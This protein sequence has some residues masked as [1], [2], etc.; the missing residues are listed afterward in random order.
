MVRHIFSLALASV[1][2]A[3]CAQT[4]APVAFAPISFV[5][6]A[7]FKI[8]APRIEIVEVFSSPM[9]PP[10]IEHLLPSSP[11]TLVRS[12]VRDR[13]QANGRGGSFKVVIKDA[14]V[15]A[16]D[17]PLKGGIEGAFTRQQAVNLNARIVVSLEYY[18][19]NGADSSVAVTVSRARTLSEGLSPIERDKAYYA[20]V[21]DLASD[22]DRE[23]QSNMIAAMR[24]AML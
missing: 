15:I 10:H 3:A 18:R 11:T 20:F 17:L 5:N 22:L 6:G 4:P 19:A 23:L 9:T 8:D 2:L 21:K 1:L 12:W 7:P 14:S 16:E 13:L 24:D